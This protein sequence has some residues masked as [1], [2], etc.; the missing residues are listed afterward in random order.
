MKNFKFSTLVTLFL[1]VGMSIFTSCGKDDNTGANDGDKDNL[2][3]KFELTIDGKKET[4]TKVGNIGVAAINTRTI[5]AE[6]DNIILSVIMEESE[7]KVGRTID[8]E[9]SAS[10]LTI[11]GSASALIQSGELKIVSKTKVELTNCVFYDMGSQHK[12]KV[13]GYISSK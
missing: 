2:V 5:S 4:G 9:S 3:G 11:K 7:F 12:Y 13:S 8:M 1:V 10:L 6:N